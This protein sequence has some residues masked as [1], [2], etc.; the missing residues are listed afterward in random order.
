LVRHQQRAKH[1]GDGQYCAADEREEQ[2]DRDVEPVV[3]ARGLSGEEAALHEF[4]QGEGG[5][6]ADDGDHLKGLGLHAD[7]SD[8]G[9]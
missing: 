1:A 2:R 4:G 9:F 5:Q 3:L 8:G 7:S 6:H